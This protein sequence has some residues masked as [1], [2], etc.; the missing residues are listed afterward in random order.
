MLTRAAIAGVVA[1]VVVVLISGI[2]VANFPNVSRTAGLSGA[3]AKA[4]LDAARKVEI[5]TNYAKLPLSFE[6]NLGQS[7]SRVKFMARGKRLCVIAD[8][9][10]SSSGLARTRKRDQRGKEAPEGIAPRRRRR[11]AAGC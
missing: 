5:A 10:G 8:A 9:E 4:S 1:A 2:L 11:L 7:D 6:A 3:S